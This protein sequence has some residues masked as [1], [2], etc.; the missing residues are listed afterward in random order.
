[1]KKSSE[2]SFE[3]INAEVKLNIYYKPTEYQVNQTTR[4]K[5]WHFVGK[6][7]VQ[8]T[9]PWYLFRS[10]TSKQSHKVGRIIVILHVKKLGSWILSDM[11]Q[12]T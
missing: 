5:Y 3:E 4:K 7:Y 9:G 10:L 2:T 8:G 1:M 12:I 6:Y 11:F